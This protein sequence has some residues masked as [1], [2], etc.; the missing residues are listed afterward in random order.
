MVI[1]ACHGFKP[2]WRWNTTQMLTQPSFLPLHSS[3]SG[4][5]CT[6]CMLREEQFNNWTKK[7]KYN[8]NGNNNTDN[9]KEKNPKQTIKSQCNCSLPAKWCQSSLP[10]PR[11]A[12][13]LGNSPS[14]YE[15]HGAQWCDIPCWPAWVTCPSYAP[16]Q[17]SGF[18]LGFLFAHLLSGRAWHKERKIL[19]LR[20][21][22]T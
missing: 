5:R 9:R 10:Q 15:W 7:V 16:S 1:S 11:L 3:G 6:T 19:W 13:P 22:T 2:S 21:E 8:S 12:S 14:L 20:I 17:F 18:V 4:R